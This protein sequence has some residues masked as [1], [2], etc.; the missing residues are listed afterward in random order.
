[1]PRLLVSQLENGQFLTDGGLET[2]LLFRDGWDLPHFASFVLLD[3]EKGRA[4]LWNYYETY[5]KIAHRTRCGFVLESPT[6]RSN[7]DW[8]HKIGISPEDLDV[9]NR[10]AIELMHELRQRHQ[11]S[12]TPV[13]ISGCVGPRGDGYDPGTVMTVEQAQAYHA[14]QIDVLAGAGAD[15][16]SAITMTTSSEAAGVARAAARANVPGVISFTVETDGNLP[17]GQSLPDAIREV[18][19]LTGGSVAYYMINCAHPTHFDHVLE[20]GAPWLSRIR[21][22]RANA[23]RM[24]HQELDNSTELDAGD[25]HELGTQYGALLRRLPHLTVLGGCCGTDDRHIS[26]IGHAFEQTRA[27]QSSPRSAAHP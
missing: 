10:R 11:Q 9:A 17:T 25:P 24:S 8:A 21:G 13:V 14:V 23:S 1:M 3:S 12:G 16:V 18:D 26:C 27:P 2:T 19:S 22:I 5:L 15:L 4:A 6:W 20:P 7:P